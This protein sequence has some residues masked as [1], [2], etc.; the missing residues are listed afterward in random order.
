MESGLAV[1]FVSNN[2]LRLN[3][4]IWSSIL[5]MLF[6]L[7]FQG[8]SCFYQIISDFKVTLAGWCNN[9][10]SLTSCNQKQNILRDGLNYPVSSMKTSN[11]VKY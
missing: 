1:V 10:P 2:L 5:R 3:V 11:I 8:Y 9:M 7:L 6:H 4:E